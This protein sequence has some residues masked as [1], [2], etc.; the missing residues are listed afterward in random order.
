MLTAHYLH[1]LPSDYDLNAIRTR[2]KARGAL[3]DDAPDLYFKGFLLREAGKHGA[4]ENSYSSLYLWRSDQAFAD[5]LLADRYRNVTN[6]FG[7]AQIETRL[8]LAAHKG[9]ALQTAFVFEETVEI[10][11]D[12]D[13][14][15]ALTREV[16]RNKAATAQPGVV[17]AVTALDT[18][19]W[20]FSRYLLTEHEEAKPGDTAV[21]YEAVHL[22][23]PLLSTLPDGQPV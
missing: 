12:A 22:S 15:A 5:F 10:A 23:Q 13:L 16:A 4:I 14:G 21:A 3:W 7:R 9:R 11:R 20:R 17:A 2:G 1:R 8:V 19:G 6:T 18:V